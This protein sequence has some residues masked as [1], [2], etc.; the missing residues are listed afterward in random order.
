MAKGKCNRCIQVENENIARNLLKLSIVNKKRAHTHTVWIR[1]KL[2][3][4]EIRFS[5]NVF[6]S[7]FYIS[8]LR[9]FQFS[10]STARH[11]LVGICQVSILVWFILFLIN[12]RNEL[13]WWNGGWAGG[14]GGWDVLVRGEDG[15]GQ[16]NM[17]VPRVTF[18]S[19]SMGNQIGRVHVNFRP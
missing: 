16:V 13:K 11:F 14:G 4:N 17:Y 19:T 6:V 5:W 2:R 9:L 7:L 12:S 3:S 10:A 8:P 15:S 18:I 1:F